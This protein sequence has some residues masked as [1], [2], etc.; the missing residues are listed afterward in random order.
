MTAEA[1]L[2]GDILALLNVKPKLSLNQIMERGGK[3]IAGAIHAA[4][5]AATLRERERC[6][7][8][9]LGF[10]PKS[11]QQNCSCARCL[12]LGDL[13]TAIREARQ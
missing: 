13:A 3:I 10:M 5:E 1:E 4:E 11:H 6:A 7:K 9:V 2:A 8:I 12:L